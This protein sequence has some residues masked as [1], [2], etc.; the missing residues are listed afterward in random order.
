MD[1]INEAMNAIDGD[2]E[3]PMN[4]YST[5]YLD[6][7]GSLTVDLF[8]QNVLRQ[9]L[10]LAKARPPLHDDTPLCAQTNNPENYMNR[11]DVRK[12]LHIPSSLPHWYDCK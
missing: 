5:C 11:A 7:Q 1:M 2:V 3:N 12:A 4:L 8:A 9:S 6:G 10:G